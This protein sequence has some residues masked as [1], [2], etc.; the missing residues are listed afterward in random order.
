MS[1]VSTRASLTSRCRIERDAN[2]AA[3]DG[4]WGTPSSAAWQTHLDNLPCRYWQTQG[5]E[6]VDADT[7]VDIDDVRLIVAAD[8]DVTNADRVAFVTDRGVTVLDGPL[9]VR[10]VIRTRDHIELAL[11]RLT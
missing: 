7:F 8:T 11:V 10:G 6:L 5:R 1:V 2:A 4:P 3:T 9:A